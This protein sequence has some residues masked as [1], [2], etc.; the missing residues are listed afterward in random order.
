MA[1]QLGFG[2]TESS[3]VSHIQPEENAVLGGCGHPIPNTIAK[4]VDLETGAALGPNQDGELCV[5][6]PQVSG[7]MNS[8]FSCK[9]SL[10]NIFLNHR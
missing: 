8:S 6:G 1:N 7:C 5:S 9:N 2:M 4:I 3:P 10:V